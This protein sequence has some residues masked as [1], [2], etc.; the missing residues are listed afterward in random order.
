MTMHTSVVW[1]YCC[2]V[3]L[4]QKKTRDVTKFE[5]KGCEL[6]VLLADLKSKL[7]STFGFKSTDISVEVH[8]WSMQI[9]VPHF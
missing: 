6:R 4:A 8:V 7:K 9:Y 2:V 1:T 5:F 3:L